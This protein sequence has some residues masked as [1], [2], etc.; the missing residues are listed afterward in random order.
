MVHLTAKRRKKGRF[1]N[2]LNPEYFSRWLGPS[3]RPGMGE[4]DRWDR[5]GIGDLET[6]MTQMVADVTDVNWARSCALSGLVALT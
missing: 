3:Q 1:G 4:G 2:N 6:L 5:W